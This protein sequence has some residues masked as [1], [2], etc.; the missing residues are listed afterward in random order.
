[1]QYIIE[2]V[3]EKLFDVVITTCGTLD[4]DIARSTKDYYQGSFFMDD[5]LQLL[6]G[7]NKYEGKIV[8]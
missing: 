3:K 8:L 1:M 7:V 6:I 4:H 5:D 2:S